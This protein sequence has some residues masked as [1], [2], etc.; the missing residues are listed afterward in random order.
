MP[1][2]PRVAHFN[3]RVTNRLTGPLAPRLPGFGVVLHTGRTSGKDYRTPVNVFRH[4]DRYVIALTYGSE[5]DWVKNVQAAGRCELLTRGRRIQLTEP[6]LVHDPTRR[7][8]P[9]PVRIPLS[10]LDVADFLCLTSMGV[11]G[12]P[13]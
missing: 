12:T 5:A 3:R 7:L 9:A 13:V 1:L 6:E 10:L 11:T 4:G 2:G 8:V